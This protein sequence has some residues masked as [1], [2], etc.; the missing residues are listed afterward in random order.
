LLLLLTFDF[1]LPLSF[2]A[3]PFPPGILNVYLWWYNRLI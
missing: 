2:P 3:F 1:A